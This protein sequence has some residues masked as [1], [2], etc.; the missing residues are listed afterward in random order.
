MD[1]QSVKKTLPAL[2]FTK[3]K[4]ETTSDDKSVQ[5]TAS[6]RVLPAVTAP[7]GGDAWAPDTTITTCSSEQ[8]GLSTGRKN[9][10]ECDLGHHGAIR[11]IG[12][13]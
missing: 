6:S 4:K 7:V 13:P 1:S 8:H 12:L 10:H 2:T 3:Q 11:Y 5:I 9:V